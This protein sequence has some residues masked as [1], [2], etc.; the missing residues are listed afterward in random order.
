MH[1]KLLCISGTKISHHRGSFEWPPWGWHVHVWSQPSD[2]AMANCFSSLKS[3]LT[4]FFLREAAPPPHPGS[5]NE[6]SWGQEMIYI[7]IC[8]V[9]AQ[10]SRWYKNSWSCKFK[11]R[12]LYWMYVIPQ[13]KGEFKIITPMKC[14]PPWPHTP[15]CL[16]SL[17]QGSLSG[18]RCSSHLP[19]FYCSEKYSPTHSHTSY[20]SV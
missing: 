10:V 6:P 13:L 3:L 8:V 2:H 16:I 5:L 17:E 1:R 9:T 15:L 14:T 20:V 11:T 7:L 18:N 19:V 4:R 12:V